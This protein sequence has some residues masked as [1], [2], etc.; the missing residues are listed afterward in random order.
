MLHEQGF[1]CYG[2]DSSEYIIKKFKRNYK[3][4]A[5]VKKG[6]FTKIPFKKNNFDA[7]I[8]TGVLYYESKK[9]VK[10]GFEEM[11]RVLKPGGAARIYILSDLDYKYKK[12]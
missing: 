6:S 12:K 8:C 5:I 2:I 11:Y 1:K 4:N 3:G 7:V 10:I 9:N